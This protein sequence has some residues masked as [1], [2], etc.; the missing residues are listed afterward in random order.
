LAQVTV[1]RFLADAPSPRKPWLF[2]E[3][4]GKTKPAQYSVT[5]GE[6]VRGG[7]LGWSTMT[8]SP[9]VLDEAT[10]LTWS[11]PLADRSA[12]QLDP[13]DYTALELERDGRLVVL[14]RVAG[15][16]YP[17]VEHLSPEEVG[18]LIEAVASLRVLAQLPEEATTTRPQ[19]VIRATPTQTLSPRVELQ[20]FGLVPFQDTMAYRARRKGHPGTFLL[21]SPSVEALA[22]LL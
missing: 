10:V 20:I 17:R 2:V 9:F 21:S 15:E 7:Y 22:K 6:R 3:F 16:F 4:G 11:L 13:G 12:A 14:E 18:P 19:L 1:V 8:P 5:V